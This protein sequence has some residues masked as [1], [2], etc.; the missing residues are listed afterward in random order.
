MKK[1]IFLFF[2]ALL[3]SASAWADWC[4]DSFIT[5]NGLWCTGSNSYV[6]EGGNFH[7]K[8][9]GTLTTLELGGEFQV[10]PSSTTA[11]TLCYKI[12]DGTE[13]SISL[14]K[15]KDE[16][17]NSK[18]SGSGAVDL[19]GLAEG[20]HSIA[21][22]FTHGSDID[23]NGGSN[24]VATFTIAAAGE[25]PEPVAD[26][27]IY[28]VNTKSWSSVNAYVWGTGDVSYKAWPG[29]A[30]TSTGDKAH[31]YDV[32]SYTFPETYT[33]CIF[34]GNGQTDDLTVNAGQYYDIASK[35]W[36]ATLAEVPNPTP[37]VMETVYFINTGN[38]GKVNAY[39]WTSSNNGWP[40]AE[41]TPEAEQ[42][43]GFDVYSFTAEQGQWANLIFNNGEGTQTGDLTWQAGKYYAPLKNEWYD[44]KEAAAEALA[45]PVEYEYVY[46]I[47]T[48]D[49]AAAHIYTWAPEVA[50]W[51]GAAMT[52]EAEQ[53]A[54]K[55]VYSYKVVKGTT[56][57]GLNFNCG[58][59]ECKT[60]DLT[61]QAGKYYAPSKDK[62]Y[63]TKE[64]AETALATPT[65]DV[66]TVVGSAALCGS[67]WNA[68]DA[69]NDMTLVDGLYVWTKENVTLTGNASFKI[70][71]NHDYGQ[72]EWPSGYGQ[73][74]TIDISTSECTEG[75]TYSIKITFN[76][77]TGDITPTIEECEGAAEPIVHT[78]TVVGQA[79]LCGSDWNTTDATN[80]MA[81]TDGI[82]VW[83]KENVELR[84]NAEFRIVK[85]HAYDE[86]YPNGGNYVIDLA[87]YE[88]AAIYNVTITFNAETK[89][90]TVDMEKTGDVTPVVYTYYL[91]GVNGDWETGIEMEVNTDAENE[92]MLTCQPVNGEV[93]IKRLGDDESVSWFGGKSLKDEAGNLGTNTEAATDGDGNIALE[94]GIYNFY[95]NTADGKLWIAAA[96]DCGLPTI[97]LTT[98]D[99]STVIA[100][101]IDKTVNVKIERSFTANA[102]YYTLCVPFNMDPSVIGK[103]YYLGDIKKHV[104]GEGI[105][106]ELVEETYMLSAGVPYLVLPKANMSELVVENVTIQSDEAS[107]QNI[108]GKEELNVQIFFEGFYSASGQTN[109]TTQYYVGNNGYLYNEVVDIRGLCGLFTIT[110]KNGDPLKVRA[111]VVT[112]EEVET[113]IDNNQLPNTNIQKVLENGQLIIIRE[114][115]KYNVQG[116]VIK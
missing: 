19:S 3:F 113:G 15:E 59:D 50:G 22:W 74:A 14:P 28:F 60:G 11:G 57:G 10:W 23:N 71:K 1:S 104:S 76:P 38:W 97:T 63:D 26:V 98:G 83:T 41:M 9:L 115:V 25:E 35:T 51:P 58:G 12:D 66:Y 7:G 77:A 107:G 86:A 17:N 65:E 103:A 95:F 69:T 84:S 85:D 92:V 78:Y 114:G 109:G 49:W 61:W 99:N 34:N 100:A 6:H 64:A 80:D 87:N 106:I 21:V 91:M 37:A 89:E 5:V 2:A 24:Y 110:D 82:Y 102:G 70:V 90:I 39:A 93:K 20:S 44:T 4:G 43:A 96:T 94:E 52:L 18:H 67:D 111:R 81:L 42:I 45:A 55:D 54:G 27:T 116:Q 79:V 72:G 48:N 31:G 30:M 101:N 40:G 112:R 108:A 62:W 56:F 13:N 88:G 53:I 105:D 29:E 16:G 36:Y 46:L 75:G 32:Y 68:S 47:N 33:N 8:V 73:N